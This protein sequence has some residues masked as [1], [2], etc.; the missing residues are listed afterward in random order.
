MKAF[1][2]AALLMAALAAIFAFSLPAV[3]T[4][5]GEIEVTDVDSVRQ[6]TVVPNDVL[7]TTL[8]AAAVRTVVEF[9][10]TYDQFLVSG[11]GADFEERLKQVA[12]RPIIGSA[13]GSALYALAAPASGLAAALADVGLRIELRLAER[14]VDRL[15]VFPGALLQDHEPPV[16]G[17]PNSSGAHV[18]WTTNEFTTSV[19]QYGPAK[20]DLG[21]SVVDTSLRKDHSAALDGMGPDF[22]I[23]CQITSTDQSGNVTV[24]EIYQVS[25]AR[26]LF[27]PSLLH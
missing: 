9:V 22:T 13:Q 17:R 4:P 26:N 16:I 19:I 2:T 6:E 18:N 20:Y 3:S 24:S 15:L 7:S 11:P 25:G 10:D 5:L 1:I 21:K 23:Y 8:A 12:M 14:S 27:L